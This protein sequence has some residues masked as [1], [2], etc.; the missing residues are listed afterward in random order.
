MQS[1]LPVAL[2]ITTVA[3]AEIWQ[4]RHLLDTP[5]L[6][7]EIAALLLSVHLAIEG[8]VGH[9][10]V[11]AASALISIKALRTLGWTYKHVPYIAGAIAIAAVAIPGF[12]VWVARLLIPAFALAALSHAIIAAEHPHCRYL[13]G[14]STIPLVFGISATTVSMATE[15]PHAHTLGLIA[16]ASFLAVARISWWHTWTKPLENSLR[17]AAGS[18]G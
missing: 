15:S 10:A 4:R 12:D 1:P 7:N 2:L 8:V 14:I 5:L 18:N 3:A 6:H 16:A 9:L 17:L 13:A 11:L